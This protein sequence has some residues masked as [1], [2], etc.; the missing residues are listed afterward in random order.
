[1]EMLCPH[2]YLAGVEHSAIHPRI[3]LTPVTDAHC[4]PTDLNPSESDYATVSL[5]GLAAMATADDQEA[6]ASAGEERPW[7]ADYDQAVAAVA[8][9]TGPCIVPSF[10][11]LNNLAP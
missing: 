5:G 1:M 4:H 10:G 7:P 11:E 3:P 2:W 8:S 6:V 9:S